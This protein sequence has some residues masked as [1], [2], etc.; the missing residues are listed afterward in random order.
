MNQQRTSLLYWKENEQGE[1]CVFR[2]FGDSPVL[3]VPEQIDKKLV[4]EIGMYCFSQTRRLPE[5]QLMQSRFVNDIEE[6]ALPVSCERKETNLQELSGNY[7]EEI[8]LPD[9]LRKIGKCAFY[10]C[11]N[12]KKISVSGQTEE[13]DSDAFMNCTHLATLHIRTGIGEKS[14]LKQMLA[15][16]S[17]NLEVVFQKAHNPVEAVL[18]YPEYYEEYDEIGPAHIFKL[19]LTGE[20]FRAR[21]SF[22]DGKV[23]L[24]QYD[25]IFPQA[26]VSEPVASLCR[27]AFN[28]LYYPVDLSEDAKKL[29]EDYI[30][31]HCD[32]TFSLLIAERNLDQMYFLVKN[33]YANRQVLNNTIRKTSEM[34][35]AE[36][37]ASVLA[38]E[39]EFL[40]DEGDCRY[41][42]DDFDWE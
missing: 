34:D 36:G 18:F 26:C 13:I 40:Q 35:W 5:G 16:I 28:R 6:S 33:G 9:S 21:Q 41:S 24:R 25:A 22:A 14:G 4:T 17:W 32:E 1:V 7:L 39:A 29:Y 8:I 19:N 42:F 15:Q 37:T 2:A 20:G 27:M 11:S 38:W 3:F 23:I 10:N 12:L 31:E 30:T